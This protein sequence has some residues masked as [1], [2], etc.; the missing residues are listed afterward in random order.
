MSVPGADLARWAGRFRD[1]CLAV[2]PPCPGV[3]EVCCGPTDHRHVLCGSC[4]AVGSS[5]GCA[6][7][8]VFPI[9]LAPDGSPVYASLVRYKQRRGNAAHDVGR[10]RLHLAGL[11]SLFLDRHAACLAPSLASS[12][13]PSPWEVV[14]V[15]PSLRRRAGPHPLT[16]TLRTV[17]RLRDDLAEV[18][19]PGP[20]CARVGRNAG[21]P[22]AFAADGPLV[23]GRRVLLVDDT[24]TTGA[25]L[26]SAVVAL[27]AAG[28]ASVG[29]LVVGRH[30]NREWPT[31]P[32][33]LDW[34]SRPEHAWSPD[35]CVRCAPA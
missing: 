9:S 28:A 32:P 7:Q 2:R 18:L 13:P 26:Q 34:S 31:A 30:L 11:V 25:R 23:E 6:L 19:R 21:R 35:R 15:V 17:D 4:R 24:Y 3:C 14:A 22:D 33:L 27:R 1:A 16:E 12:P 29:A 8:S 10:H 20:G 5:L